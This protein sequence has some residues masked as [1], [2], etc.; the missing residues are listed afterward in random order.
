MKMQYQKDLNIARFTCSA[1]LAIAMLGASVQAS[2]FECS[3]FE[4]KT[5]E[6]PSFTT[7]IAELK[8]MEESGRHVKVLVPVQGPVQE[9]D[10]AIYVTSGDTKAE[11]KQKLERVAGGT[12]VY[13]DLFPIE[14][15]YEIRMGILTTNPAQVIKPTV[16]AN[17]HYNNQHNEIYDLQS[18]IAVFCNS[19]KTS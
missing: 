3:I 2:A 4:G 7:E 10:L 6:I 14:K 8:N 18:K 1:L 5:N 12:V 19:S 13:I 16:Y 15:R 17:F 11:V 9:F